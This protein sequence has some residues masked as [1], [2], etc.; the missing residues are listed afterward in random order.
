MAKDVITVN[1]A[2]VACEGSGPDSGHPKIYLTFKAGG[3]EVVCP[4]C[5]RTFVLAEGAKI[6]HG[7]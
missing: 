1:S 6:A 5:S 7:H 2:T 4:Y 3:S